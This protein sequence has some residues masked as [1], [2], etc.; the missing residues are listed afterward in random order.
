MRLTPKA[1]FWLFAVAG[2]TVS[3]LYS[4]HLIFCQRSTLQFLDGV[5]VNSDMHANLLWARGIREQGWLN[6]VPYHPWTDWMQA[7]APYQQWVEWWGGEQI[8]QQSPLY[9]YV[10]SIFVKKLALMRALQ[11][12]MSIGTCFPRTLYG[13]HLRPP[14]WLDCLLAGGSLCPVL[15]LLLAL[16]ARW[17]C[18]VHH[19]GVFVGSFRIN[20]FTSAISPRPAIRLVSWC[21]TGAGLF[22]AG[23]LSLADSG[24]ADSSCGFCMAAAAVGHGRARRDCDFFDFVPAHDSE[25]VRKSAVA[26]QLQSIGGGYRCRKCRHFTPLRIRVPKRNGTDSLRNSRATAPRL[27]REHSFPP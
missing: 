11:A 1:N 25:L 6:P 9:A 15:R 13:A 10:L 16:F 17:A 19:R 12:L 21:P 14:R 23:N 24:S 5:F 26:I 22:G 7:F 27:S 4:A 8:F 2:L 3:L 18:L 20:L